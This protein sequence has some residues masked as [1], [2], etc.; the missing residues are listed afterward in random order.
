[1]T[2]WTVA[3]THPNCE[4]AAIHNLERQGF[5]YYHPKLLERKKL[6][7]GFDLVEVP[8]FPC[9]MF[10]QIVDKW[11]CLHST[12]GIASL[13]KMGPSLAI[14]Q[15]SVID[16]L[17]QREQN[18]YIQLPKAK[19]LDIGDKVVIQTGP[20]AQQTALVDR[21]PVKDRQKILLALLDAKIKVLISP[22]DLLAA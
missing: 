7:R 15:D 1:M 5:N 13:I 19:G 3:R 22:E 8:L 6:K 10:I 21:M 17:K 20:F 14:V 4:K 11:N 18:G 2:F 16:S 9:Y 12:H